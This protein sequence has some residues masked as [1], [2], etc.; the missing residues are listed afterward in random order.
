MPPNYAAIEYNGKYR[1]LVNNIMIGVHIVMAI[2][3]IGTALYGAWTILTK[4]V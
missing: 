1:K 4:G 3:L 2:V